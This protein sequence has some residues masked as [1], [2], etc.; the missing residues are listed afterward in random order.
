MSDGTEIS[1]LDADTGLD[2]M[3][4]FVVENATGNIR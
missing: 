3:Y 2:H 4:I 1:K